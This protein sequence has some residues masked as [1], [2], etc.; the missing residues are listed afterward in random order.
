MHN[1]LQRIIK[2][3]TIIFGL[4]VGLCGVA[5]RILDQQVA[6]VPSLHWLGFTSWS[7]I[8]DTLIVLAVYGIW[9]DYV[10]NK[11]KEAHDTERLRRVLTDSAPAIRDAVIDGFAFGK[12]DL[13]RVSNPDTL[14]NI[15]RNSL[16]LRLGDRTFADE[17]YTDIRDQAVKAPE[18]WLDAKVA[19]HLSPLGIPRG[20]A[21]GG[22]SSSDQA[23]PLFVVTVRWE[24]TVIPRFHTRRFACVSDRTEYHDLMEDSDDTSAWW[25]TPKGGLNANDIEAFEVVQFTVNGEERP[26]RRAERKT[27]QIY[28]VGLGT[29]PDDDTPVTISYTYRSLVAERGHLLY[30]DIEQP[31]RGIEV[32]LDYGDCNVERVT[33]LD[34]IASSQATRIERTPESVP[35]RSVR[36]SFDGWAFPRS[37]F[38][39]VWVS[40][41]G[42]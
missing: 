26:I 29:P 28:T 17:V 15:I 23:E 1:S 14:D 37:G 18:R 3:Q 24:Y 6:Q 12:E 38:G 27:G 5:L 22:A 41:Q 40:K 13:G 39:F 32:E 8:G 16:A 34:L 35:G 2:L 11:D 9:F 42:E 21:V 36:V 25:F 4:V 7:G 20:T 19:V 33:V 31:T 10:T 30:I